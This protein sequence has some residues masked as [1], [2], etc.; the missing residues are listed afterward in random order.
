MDPYSHLFGRFVRIFQGFESRQYLTLYQPETTALTVDLKRM[1]IRFWVNKFQRLQSFQLRIEID[2]HQDAG[3]WYGFDSKLVC[4]DTN[5]PTQRSILIPLGDLEVVKRGCHVQV[6]VTPVC[7]TYVH[8]LKYSINTTLGR[9]ESASEPTMVYKKAEV[10]ALTSCGYQ[11]DPLTGRTGTEEALDLLASGISQPWTS[12]GTRP[13]KILQ[14]LAR[15]SPRR[16]W[17]PED[18]RSMKREHWDTR[19]P[20]SNQHDAFRP[21]VEVILQKSAKLGV[22]GPVTATELP[23][24]PPDDPYLS[25]RAL[26][27]R[28][29]H[30]RF[31]ESLP[32]PKAV[33]DLKYRSRDVPSD[34]SVKYNNAFEIVDIVKAGRPMLATVRNLPGALA[35]CPS[36]QGYSEEFQQL[37]LSERLDIDVCKAW[38]PLVNHLRNSRCQYEVMFLLATISFRYNAPT[39][40]IR[41]IAAF[42][43]FEELR[44]LEYPLVTEYENLR[45][46]Q[47]PTAENLLNAI[48]PYKASG[49]EDPPLVEFASVKAKR[50]LFQARAI[51]EANAN[52]ECRVFAE[53]LLRQWPCQ[54]P[55]IDG[56]GTLEL[57][58]VQL[59]L[60]AVLPEWQRLH[61]NHVFVVHL[62]AVQNRI[63]ARFADSDN[64][65]RSFVTTND[66]FARPL[67]RY[68]IPQLGKDLMKTAVASSISPYRGGI[69]G[70]VMASKST[71]QERRTEPERNSVAQEAN[72][73]RKEF[74]ST[75]EELEQIIRRVDNPKSAISRGYAKDLRSSLK[76]L[77]VHK[78]KET[79]TAMNLE[80]PQTINLQNR[81]LQQFC[82][83]DNTLRQTDQLSMEQIQWLIQG[84]L[85]PIITIVTLLQQLRSNSSPKAS[86]G[87]GMKESLV[88]MGLSITE[89]QR[90][91]RITHYERS[92]QKS[93]LEE[94]MKNLGHTNWSPYKNPDWLLLEIESEI[95]IRETQVDVAM[96]IANPKSDGNSV[97]QM[98]M[99]QGKTSCV[100]PMVATMLADT[101]NLVRVI[102]P[103]ALLQQTA[104]LLAT[105]LGSL[106]GRQVRHIPFS[107]R[108][109]TKEENIK[110][111]HSL[112]REI[113]KQSG[114]M[115]C[116]PEHNLS[117]MLSGQQRLLDQRVPEASVMIRTQQWLNSTARDIMDESDHILAVRTQLIYPSG[118]LYS[119]DG[120]PARWM[121]IEAIFALV[122]SHLYDLEKTFPQSV[123]VVRRPQGGF[124]LRIYLLRPDVGEELILR[125]RNDILQGRMG[126]L[127]MESLHVQDKFAIREFLSGGKMRPTSIDRIARLC[128]DQVHIRQTVYLLRGLLCQRILISTLRKRWN[129]EYGLHP[130]RDPIAVPFLAKGVPSEQS[131]Y[132]HCDVAILREL[133]TDI[134]R[135]SRCHKP[136]ALPS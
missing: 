66:L 46:N 30:H 124:P 52:R 8:Y 2:T 65:R 101:R 31:I 80:V 70:S 21:L 99:G 116:V 34:T 7:S 97:L 79:V 20:V 85:W 38:G 123:Q 27:R 57:V 15:L 35:Q 115:L 76:A 109:S 29:L 64:P 130:A 84:R 40:L 17:Y 113:Q 67:R 117:F 92:G 26:I 61:Q 69:V 24:L 100:I 48:G 105:S 94:E 82:S 11:P 37:S 58:D 132:G 90:R 73:S 131:E 42:F 122:D 39:A 71:M 50:R 81:I 3:T 93:R 88:D 36:I 91:R 98:N 23:E 32:Q 43:L 78:A 16:E 19:H 103:K 55:T 9:L 72:H 75:L 127:P 104:Q 62:E 112:H 114:I 89:L 135:L 4:K 136:S 60:E 44:S 63:G 77:K 106:L 41:T 125:L 5:D 12:L 102:I 56:L 13:V 134:P 10:H 96:A 6:F 47:V 107:R 28:Q 14:S 54:S 18:K 121:V 95:L 74:L 126:I 45:V 22:F 49:P 59:G 129:V 111:Y 68:G 108:T 1:N 118:S 51:H 53:H 110:L 120:H 33:D 119:V 133:P 83:L 87:T 86:F 25:K 128:P